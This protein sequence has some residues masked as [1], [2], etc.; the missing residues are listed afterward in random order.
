[1]RK[2]R[3]PIDRLKRISIELG[4]ATEASIK[5]IE[6]AVRAEV[7][8]AVAFAKSDQAIIHPL[9]PTLEPRNPKP[10]PRNSDPNPKPLTITGATA[11]GALHRR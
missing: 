6:K 4:Y 7:D 9:I 10:K 3:D 8:E 1:M 11:L 5:D 2:E